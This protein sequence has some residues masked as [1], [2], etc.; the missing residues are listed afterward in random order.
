MQPK[1]SIYSGPTGQ[2]L[3]GGRWPGGRL[4]GA[5]ALDGISPGGALGLSQS[6]LSGDV[7]LDPVIVAGALSTPLAPTTLVTNAI[8]TYFTRPQVRRGPDGKYYLGWCTNDG[9][10]GMDRFNVSAG[11]IANQQS[12]VLATHGEIDD[13]DNTSVHFTRDG[14]LA[15]YYGTHNSSQLRYRVLQAAS[16]ASGFATIGSWSAEQLRGSTAGYSYQSPVVLSQDTSAEYLFFRRWLNVG[17]SRRSICFAKF[18]NMA[19]IPA[20]FSGG[21]VDVLSTPID[22]AWSYWQHRS[23]GVDRIDVLCTDVPQNVGQASVFHFYMKLDGSN[24]MRYYKTDGTEIT[25]SLPFDTSACTLIYDGST[26][27]GWVSDIIL[28]PDGHP[29]ALW[30][31]FI[32]NN[33]DTNIEYWLSRWTGSAWTSTKLCDSGKGFD[34]YPRW[35]HRG[36][37]FHPDHPERIVMARE[38]GGVGTIEEWTSSDG[39]VS[40]SHNRTIRSTTDSGAVGPLVRPVGVIGSVGDINYIWHEGPF[41]GFED[42]STNLVGAG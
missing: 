16:I 21:F 42:Y 34:P 29:R 25:A 12:V 17:G 24:V 22:N 39:C 20:T 33:G 23:N 40:Y 15:A 38:I 13:H 2:A 11:A 4:S 10:S 32:G 30:P 28:G 8:W 5:I 19:T 41:N 37:E 3:H 1:L 35:Y 27:R 14:A 36:F 9:R 6:A 7:A 31:K 18:A 26:T